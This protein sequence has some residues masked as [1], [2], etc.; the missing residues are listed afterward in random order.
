[1]KKKIAAILVF[2]LV[3]SMAGTSFAI[4][5]VEDPIP[6]VILEVSS[7]VCGQE[8]YDDGSEEN[9]PVVYIANGEMARLSEPGFWAEPS[10]EPES[11]DYLPF[12]GTIVGDQ[13]YTAILT[14]EAKEGSFFNKDSRLRVY[15]DEAGA[16]VECE[17]IR[18]DSG[19]IVAAVSKKAVHEWN[20]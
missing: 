17:P 19:R 6:E 13:V 8:V 16:L 12:E 4:E 9:R 11:S 2:L 5:G 1:M 15:D 18:R 7:P 3:F 10:S 14:I 20:T